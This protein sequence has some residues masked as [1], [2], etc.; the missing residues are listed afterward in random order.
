M[1]GVDHPCLKPLQVLLPS[2][3]PRALALLM[4]GGQRAAFGVWLPVSHSFHPSQPALPRSRTCC[5][6][7]SSLQS[8]TC[9]CVCVLCV[10]V[11]VLT[12][13]LNSLPE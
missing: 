1:L 2:P 4:K 6:T 13:A 8:D 3:G 5:V 10:R 11:H 7:H 12:R 9:V